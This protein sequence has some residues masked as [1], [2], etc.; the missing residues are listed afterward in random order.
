[1]RWDSRKGKRRNADGELLVE[2]G[3][4]ELSD[5]LR[6]FGGLTRCLFLRESSFSWGQNIR[7]VVLTLQD[8]QQ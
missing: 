5:R 3:L 6:G 4:S 8:I 2:F 7:R 1:M